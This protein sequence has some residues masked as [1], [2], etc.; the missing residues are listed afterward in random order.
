VARFTRPATATA[1]T[2]GGVPGRLRPPTRRLALHAFG[3]VRG[4]DR[5]RA[6]R[7]VGGQAKWYFA[8]CGGHLY[9]QPGGADH[10]YVRLGALEWD[11]GIRPS[12]RQWVSSAVSWEAI[13]YDGLPRFDGPGST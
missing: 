6:W 13:P 4:A 11:P 1:T 10:V 8:D 5:L 2:A 9:S 12:Y 7:P 3:V